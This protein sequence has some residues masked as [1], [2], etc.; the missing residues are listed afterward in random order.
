M[1]SVACAG[2]LS[3]FLV[4]VD[5][6]DA[7]KHA[8]KPAL[9]FW[10]LRPRVKPAYLRGLC[11]VARNRQDGCRAVA[12]LG[13]VMAN[14]WQPHANGLSRSKATVATE[15][16]LKLGHP[17]ARDAPHA[18]RM[19][20]LP[21]ADRSRDAQ[22][23]RHPVTGGTLVLSDSDP[24]PHHRGARLD[25]PRPHDQAGRG[26]G[27]GRKRRTRSRSTFFSP[28]CPSSSCSRRLP[29]RAT[30]PTAAALCGHHPGR[31]VRDAD[32]DD[33][34]RTAVGHRHRRHGPSRPFQRV[35]DVGSGGGSGRRRRHAPAG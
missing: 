26:R 21:Q 9:S 1:R 19:A 8:P 15:P 13:H 35:G 23:P 27:G 7:A 28:G 20:A 33:H 30:P 5:V 18:C 10:E 17:R 14:C 32:P 25:L 4:F 31:A 29:S 24:R 16:K 22:G 2:S 12:Q 3:G 34:R 11:P 6:S